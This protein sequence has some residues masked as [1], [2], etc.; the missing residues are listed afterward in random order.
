MARQSS[1][2]LDI[3]IVGAGLGGLA[4]A[5]SCAQAGHH[6][7][8]CESTKALGEVG[9]GIQISPNGS[10]ILTKFGLYD[11]LKP[12]AAEPKFLAIRRFQ[13][14]KVL[15]RTDNFDLEMRS[16]YSAPFWELHRN[17]LQTAMIDRAIGLGVEVRL[18]SRVRDIDFDQP[19]VTLENGTV[20]KADLVVG[21]DGLWSKCR[22]RFLATQGKADTPI[23]TGDL[24]YRIVLNRDEVTDPELRNWIANPSVQFWI[25][26]D[27]HAVA[28]SLRNGEIFNIVLLVPDNLP[29]SISRQRASLD[30]MRS[31]FSNWDP[32]L[33]RF[34][35][36][37]KSVDKWKLMNRP[38][39][40]NWINEKANFVIIGDACHPMLP[41]IA[42][43]ANT[44]ME[45]GAALGTILS[46]LE[47]R[48]EL[49]RAMHL[50]QHIRKRRGE[51]IVR[52]AFRQRD[53]YHMHDGP[54][55]VARDERLATKNRTSVIADKEFP[56]RWQCPRAQPWIFG[57]DAFA[58]TE[59]T[60]LDEIRAKGKKAGRPSSGAVDV[61]YARL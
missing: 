56:V 54:E 43:G 25:G 24:A 22:E 48:D 26:P 49:P 60:T 14:G 38:E 11:T 52:E 39:L 35:D 21:A 45:D 27:C 6:V 58:L 30:E 51:A 50:Y 55:Q 9:A 42:Q 31:I 3:L 29:A 1:V 32:V 47:S 53:D 7:T 46:G 37:V 17:D 41:Y 2:S 18:N 15:S 12:K 19:A 57:Y 23:P 40:P 61:D 36:Q 4:A 44:S 13:D 33:N 10:R 5:I 59:P 20:L 16:K 8:I 34:L 28:Y